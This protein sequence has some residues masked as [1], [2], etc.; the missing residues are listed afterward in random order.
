MLCGVI[1][2]FTCVE[3][4]TGLTNPC[5]GKTGNNSDSFS[6]GGDNCDCA[7]SEYT[8]CASCTS[9]PKCD[10]VSLCGQAIVWTTR[11]I[12]KWLYLWK[13]QMQ[14]ILGRWR[15]GNCIGL[16]IFLDCPFPLTYAKPT[17]CV[18]DVKLYVILWFPYF[19]FFFFFLSWLTLFSHSF[20]AIRRAAQ[21]VLSA[22]LLR[23]LPYLVLVLVPTHT[24]QLSLKDSRGFAR[25][26]I[27]RAMS[28]SLLFLL[29]SV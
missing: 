6:L 14:N 29:V 22:H 27:F 2:L 20:G 1:V 10:W 16:S 26:A 23:T 11:I 7:S 8:D 21:V 28:F 18:T 17:F 25:S 4:E 13:M 5:A 12:V 15:R 24:Y 19:Q 3:S 9:N